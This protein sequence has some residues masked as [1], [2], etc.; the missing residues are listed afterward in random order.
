MSQ[1]LTQKIIIRTILG[2]VLLSAGM[3]LVFTG[4]SS[5]LNSGETNQ[6]IARIGGKSVNAVEFSRIYARALEQNGL[7]DSMARQMGVPAMI[8]QREIERQILAQS[9]QKMGIRID[10]KYVATQLKQQ[11][12]NVTVSG[13][14]QEKLQLVLSQQKMSE[15]ELVE[16]LRSDFA[17]NLLA[18]SV[19]T[20]DLNVPPTLVASSYRAEKEQRSADIIPITQANIKKTPVNE[21][22]A[23]AF[24]EENKE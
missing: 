6:E 7:Q 22:D 13:T 2:I 16:L 1:T 24:F 5:T 19:A 23:K 3:A 18:S 12:N 21:T 8:L 15:S 11:L 9:A 14:P 20:G 4:N 17:I 10:N